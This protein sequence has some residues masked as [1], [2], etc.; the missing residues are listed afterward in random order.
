MLAVRDHLDQ[1]GPDTA[2]ALVTF[3]SGPL[4]AD[5]VAHHELPFPVL[6]DADRAAYRAYGLARGTRRRVWG[7]RAARRYVELLRR[8]GVRGLRRPVEDPLQLGGDFVVAPDGTLSYGFWGAGP[9]ERPPMGELVAA[10]R[11]TRR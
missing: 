8:D 1:L 4:L 9:D 10:V 11:R 2:V 5:Y 7:L 3:S 6:S